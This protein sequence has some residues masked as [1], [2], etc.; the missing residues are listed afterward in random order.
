MS[1]GCYQ[2]ATLQAS[3]HGLPDQQAE[4][5]GLPHVRQGAAPPG[6][7]RTRSST[8][9]IELSQTL[10]P[11]GPAR[12]DPPQEPVPVR[13]RLRRG[14]PHPLRPAALVLQH[15]RDLGRPL[16]SRREFEARA[17]RGRRVQPGQPL[18]EAGH[19]HDPAEVRHRL[20]RARRPLNAS[21]ALV[22]V[23]MADGS[24]VVNHGGVEMGQ[25]LH[26]KIA[27]VAANDAGHPPGVDPRRRQQQRRDRQRPRHGRLDRLRPQ[28]RGRREGVPGPAQPARGLLPRPGAVPARTT[29]SS[30]WRYDWAGCWPEI[31]FQAWFNRV[32][33]SAAELY[34]SPALRG[35]GASD[36]RTGQSFLYFVYS[37]AVSEV[38]IDVLTGEF[39]ILR[40]D[41]LL[42][43][44]QVAQPGH[45]H[46]PDRG[47]LRA[48]GRLRRPP[49][50]SSTTTHG[51]LVTDNI[52]SY[53]PPC[54]KTIPLDFRVTLHARR[55]RAPRRAG[56]GRAAGG[57]VVEVARASRPVAGRSR[58]TSPSS[59]PS[60]PPAAT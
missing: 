40:A 49:R 31:V 9:P 26:T 11:A 33:L 24:V 3:G 29:A 25:G 36:T 60:W 1:D 58:P 50:R 19:R 27:Q 53:K 54:S 30:D 10:G 51:R 17:E 43:R 39:T 2:I 28:R 56:A 47:G 42:R 16:R 34:K 14:R 59:A 41:I 8:S 18:A 20:H 13:P 4:Q 48:G 5:H 32:N 46:R 44:R 55:P 7:S 45:R 37:V 6:P 52:W 12:G 22:N 21:S 38:E 35:A 57:Q 23:N 15:P